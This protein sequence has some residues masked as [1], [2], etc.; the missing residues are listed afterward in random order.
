MSRLS[1]IT[2]KLLAV[3]VL[4]MLPFGTAQATTAT[5]TAT[6]KVVKP[7]TLTAKQDLDFGQIIMVNVSGSS[8]VS[9]SQ[10]GAL[11]CGT[12][13]SCSGI[14]NA[15]IFNVTGTNNQLVH[16][17]AAASS[18]INAQNGTTIAFTPNAPSSV[19]LT[20]S[21]AP[22][23]DFNVGGTIVIPST[24][25]GGLYSGIVDITVDYQ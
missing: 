23:N 19:M 17:Y 5:A 14:T 13:L 24:V 2:A 15:A 20:S 12:G 1:K 6:V 11:T 22:G 9:I 3:A 18:L 8:S 16:I 21:G 10:A 25:T 4:A 7:L